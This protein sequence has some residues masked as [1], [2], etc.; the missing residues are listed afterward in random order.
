[1]VRRT[2]WLLVGAG[3]GAWMVVKVQRAASRL[4]PAGAVEAVQRQVRHL[5]SDVGAA[6]VE[7][8]RAKQATEQE[9]RMQAEARPA[10]D[11]AARPSL[12]PGG[13]APV[14]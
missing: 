9:L 2:F 7:G 6:L 14:A 12:P 4:T 13:G 1:M 10:I 11:V 3:M 8:R 5:R